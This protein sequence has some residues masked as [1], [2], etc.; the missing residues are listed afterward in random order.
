MSTGATPHKDAD[1][2]RA[3]ADGKQMQTEG[4]GVP[5]ADASAQDA[6]LAVLDGDPCRIKPPMFIINVVEFHAPAEIS[7]FSLGI[8]A[9]DRKQ[10]LMSA[11]FYFDS[12]QHLL[13]AFEALIKPFKGIA[14]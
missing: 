1:K 7:N 3:I 4:D 5:W 2:L 9:I 6:L 13:A 14:G 11:Q 10:R 12:E 8:A